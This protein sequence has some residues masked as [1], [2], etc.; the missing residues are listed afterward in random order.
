[1]ARVRQDRMMFDVKWPAENFAK[2][3]RIAKAQR[4]DFAGNPSP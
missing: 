4:Y 1:M 3:A 2:E